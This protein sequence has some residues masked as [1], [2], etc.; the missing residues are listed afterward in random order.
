MRMR[1]ASLRNENVRL[2]SGDNDN[3]TRDITLSRT[4]TGCLQT[5]HF[6]PK[7]QKLEG[8]KKREKRLRLLRAFHLSDCKAKTNYYSN[9]SQQTQTAQ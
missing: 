4:Q 3:T 8:Q 7:K 6:P 2:R 1:V 5:F 9:Q